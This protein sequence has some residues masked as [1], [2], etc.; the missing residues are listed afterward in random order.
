MKDFE[1][2]KTRDAKEKAKRKR[3]WWL[4][5]GKKYSYYIWAAPIMPFVE[6]VDR[7]KDNNYKKRVWDTEKASK[8]ID[9][10]L[11]HILEYDEENDCYWLN[12]DWSPYLFEKYAPRRLRKWAH[13]FSYNVRSYVFEGYQKEGWVKTIDDEDEWNKWAIFRKEEK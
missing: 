6:L 3:K 2:A 8:V 13:K 5:D 1:Y 11:P 10:T 9:A 12:F 7:I 4:I